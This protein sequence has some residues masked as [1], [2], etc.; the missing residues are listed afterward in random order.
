MTAI[1]ERRESTSLWGRF[2]NWITSTE[3]RL[4]IGW[5]GVLMIPTLLTATSVFIIAFIAA[6]PVDI[7]GI[8]EPV[9]GSLLYGNNIISGA[10]IPT[11][12]AIGLH[13]YP[14]W[15]AASVDEWLYN[16]GPYELIVLHF[17]LGVACYMGREWE[18]SFRLGMRPWIA[19]AYSA[20]VAAATAVFLI[21]PIGQGSFSDGM[22][23][24]ISGTFN[25]MIV[26]QAE[27]NIL[28][29]PFHMLGVAGVFG[30]S[31]FSAMH[32]SLV[33][34]S[35]IRE[36]TENESANEGYKFGQEE[37]TYNIVA[38]HGYFGRLIFQYASFNNSRSLHFFLA[39]WPVVGIW[40]TA[41]G[42]STMAFNLNGFNFNQS[43][44]D[45][46]G[47]VINTW[48]DIINRA[49]L[50]ME[51]MHERNAHNF[52]LDLAALEPEIPNILFQQD[53]GYFFYPFLICYWHPCPLSRSRFRRK[54]NWLLPITAF[55]ID[56]GTF[57][58]ETIFL[59]FL[60]YGMNI[61]YQFV[62][63]THSDHFSLELDNPIWPYP[64]AI[65]HY[66]FEKGN[67]MV[68]PELLEERIFNSIT[69][70]PRIWGP[71]DNLFDCRDRYAEYDWGIFLWIKEDELSETV[72]E[73]DS[74]FLQSGTMQYQTR[75]ISFKEEGFF[76]ISQLIWDLRIHSFS[77]SKIR[78]LSLCF[79]RWQSGLVPVPG[80][81]SLL[82]IWLA[83]VKKEQRM[84][85]DETL[86]VFTLVV[87]SVSIF[88]FG[89]LLFM[90]LI[91]ATRD[92]RERTKSKLVKIM[93]WAGIVV[94]TF[95]IAVRIY[96]IFIFLLK[97][98]I[99]P[100]VE[101]L[102]DKLPWIWEVSLSR[103]WDRLIDFLDR[104][105][106]ACAQRI[107]TGI[108]KQKGEF[109]VTFSCRVKKRLYARA[110]E[111]GIHLSLLSNL[112]WILKT[113][114]AVGYRLL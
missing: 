91:S 64:L 74:D 33:T 8:R 84:T 111:V 109:V 12:A 34:S 112:F 86:L 67:G 17:L 71:W 92:F 32:G 40:F 103:Y 106:W 11:S 44:V 13:F 61:P 35:L 65:C 27:H 76:R 10:I 7:D 5:F 80:E 36:T 105:L 28:M 19:V 14:I 75:D 9:S 94:I 81:K 18:L 69:W 90:V 62:I 101:A 63:L 73:T 42:I 25:F 77:Y 66:F 39:A 85:K 16:G 97:E 70:A 83:T 96:P 37:E 2:C 79:H 46:Q 22:P 114:L 110:I 50:G 3:N 72:Q 57:V 55:P 113:T 29:H 58:P 49:N 102:Y 38:A 48:A 88:L 95:A 41:L 78:P 20:P 26:F 4:Y 30:G 107:Q 104:Y 51:V 23:L 56:I 98:R 52:P 54:P 87:S 100:L 89:I 82:N 99:K 59:L 1:L 24:G 108:R 43:V 6:P 15:E 60:C 47:R 53:I 31:L 68:K 93:I 21:Y 45:S